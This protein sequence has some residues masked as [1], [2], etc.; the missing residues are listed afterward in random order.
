MMLKTTMAA[1]WLVTVCGVAASAQT[2]SAPV[3]RPF[4]GSG[5]SSPSTAG[6]PPAPQVPGPA[7]PTPT[8]TPTATPLEPPPSSPATLLPTT[9][10]VY[11]S[12]EFLESYDA[13]SGQRYYLYGSNLP[14]VEVLAFYRNALKNGGRELYKLPAMQQF[15]LGKFQEDTM[16]YPPSVVVKDYSS[17]NSSG[18]LFVSGTTEKRYRTIIQIVPPGPGK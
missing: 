1:T 11:P 9:I 8:A 18:Y 13:G 3:P 4:P 15:D 16:A 10:P 2:G 14:Y 12:A 6:T 17:A 5:T 7:N